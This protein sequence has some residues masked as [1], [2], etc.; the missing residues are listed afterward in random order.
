MQYT[1][2]KDKNLVSFMFINFFTLISIGR[3]SSL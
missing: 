1:L 3:Y 2:Y